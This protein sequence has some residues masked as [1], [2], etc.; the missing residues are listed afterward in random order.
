MRVTLA[1]TAETGGGVLRHMLDL[2]GALDRR[3]HQVRIAA[4]STATPVAAATRAAGL[5]IVGLDSRRQRADIWHLHLADTFDPRASRLLLRARARRWG[6]TVLTEHLPRT[7]ASDPTLQPGRRTPGA[8]AAKTVR[9]RT[10]LALTDQLIVVSAGSGR[11]MR[12]RYAA[13]GRRTVNVV[14]NA[15]PARVADSTRGPADGFSVLSV[16]ALI[17]QKGHDVLVDAASRGDCGYRVEIIG[18][19]AQ[20]L[21]LQQSIER[22]GAPVRLLGWRDDVEDLLR[23]ADAVCVPSRWEASSYAALEAMQ[24]G[25]PVV[26]S[27]IDGLEDIVADGETGIL[28]PPDDAAALS[29]ALDALARDPERAR[30]MG[31]A[32]RDRVARRFDLETMVDATLAVYGSA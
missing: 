14:P 3:G 19:G 26:A 6:A 24:A 12:R 9:K 5:E 11:F 28:V 30:T 32:G 21:N 31:L 29:A 13:L 22:T 7:N 27:R 8:A 25:L 15:L 17:R 23:G 20:R 4:P 10:Q 1:T 2:A 18:D 16:G